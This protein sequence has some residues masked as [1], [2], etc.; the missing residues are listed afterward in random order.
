MNTIK[1]VL[2]P[3]LSMK[4]VVTFF[5]LILINTAYSN[6]QIT[7]TETKGYVEGAGYIE[8]IG[9]PSPPYDVSQKAPKI[10]ESQWLVPQDGLYYINSTAT[11]ASDSTNGTPLSPR[12]TIPSPIPPG[13][14]VKIEGEYSISHSGLTFINAQGNDGTWKQGETGPVWFVGKNAVFTKGFVIE[15]SDLFVENIQFGLQTGAGGMYLIGS[16]KPRLAKNIVIRNCVFYGYN[17][18]VEGK[19]GSIHTTGVNAETPAKNIFIFDNKFLYNGD[20][21]ADFDQDNH[22]VQV[23]KGVDGYWFVNNLI[24]FA[25]GSGIQIL[26]TTESTK[27]IYIGSNTISNVRQAGVGIKRGKDIIISQNVFKD[28]IDTRPL[29]E[30]SKSPSKGVGYQYSSDNLWILFNDISN[31]SF[32]IYGGSDTGT[33]EGHIYVIGNYIHDISTPE[34][35]TKIGGGAWADAA[36]MLMGGKYR[37]IVNNTIRNVNSG[38]YGP[39]QSETI[40]NISQNVISGVTKG[41]HIYIQSG[42][43]AYFNANEA[44]EHKSHLMSSLYGMTVDKDNGLYW[45]GHKTT[46]QSQMVEN[47]CQEMRCFNS[48][49]I[50][51]TE[52]TN[53]NSGGAKLVSN[54]NGHD[55]GTKHYVY[56][57][58]FDLYGLS[59]EYDIYGSKRSGKWDIGSYEDSTVRTNLGEAPFK[60]TLISVTSEP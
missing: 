19:R 24:Q 5:L 32:G 14:Y 41:Q 9:I 12:K 20:V 22:M 45:A 35:I 49:N 28:I 48:D 6:E 52:N 29:Y 15:G 13:S 44:G 38:I 17:A 43:S 3:A 51:L 11:N 59:I 53:L 40:Y 54:S 31:A 23:D 30:I 2:S 33:V 58:F 34:S 46:A 56:N 18:S 27:N 1:K 50:F 7:Y 16:S 21:N 39:S 4:G 42:K 10:N 55:L 26:G 57:A 37:Y 60:P 47:V 36:I 8:T 25:S